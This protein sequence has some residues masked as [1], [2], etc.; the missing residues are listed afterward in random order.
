MDLNTEITLKR[1]KTTTHTYSYDSELQ[2]FLPNGDH[3]DGSYPDGLFA[4]QGNEERYVK[5]YH[6]MGWPDHGVPLH[7]TALLNFRRKV[8]SEIKLTES[9]CVVHCR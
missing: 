7:A 2:L 5:Q 4:L 9:P 1:E 8:K 3:S 6:F